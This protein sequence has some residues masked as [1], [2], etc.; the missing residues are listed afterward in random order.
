M[1]AVISLKP[2]LAG[3]PPKAE[4]LNPLSLPLVTRLLADLPKPNYIE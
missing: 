2:F 1:G 4:G 3:A